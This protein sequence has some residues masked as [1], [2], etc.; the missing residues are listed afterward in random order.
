MTTIKK[1]G[2]T[3]P[4]LH[5]QVT[6]DQIE[7]YA[8]AS[9]D[10]NPIHL[11]P[12]F[13]KQSSFGRIVAHGMLILSFLSEMLTTSFGQS[14]LENGRLKVRFRSPVH[15]D[16]VVTAFGSV[17]K[18]TETDTGHHV[19]CVIGCRNQNGEEVIS[20]EASLYPSSE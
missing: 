12:E 5:K 19:V 18:V 13:A 9:G 15:P 16:D 20:G 7:R 11:D 4:E 6:Q 8:R 1:I 14:W 17:T 10:F 3:L 2:D